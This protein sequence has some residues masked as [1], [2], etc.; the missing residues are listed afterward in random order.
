[1]DADQPI[2]ATV[3]TVSD[4][5]HAG[6][7]VN[8][9]GALALELLAGHGVRAELVV[10]PDDRE[11]IRSAVFEA[12]GAGARV[13]M[14]CGGTGIGPSDVTV[15]AVTP[16]LAY[17]VPGIC[18]EIRR[19]GAA[20]VASALVSREV[21]GVLLAPPASG[22]VL[23]APGSRGGVRDAIGVVGPLLGYVIAQ[24]DGARHT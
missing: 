1:M 15:D 18:E 20:H 2:R 5:I 12:V 3:V 9:A 22:F 7:D 16:M 17:Q 13:V 21:A 24:L 10:V 6:L 8:R 14:T 23:T 4:E 11:Q 19:R